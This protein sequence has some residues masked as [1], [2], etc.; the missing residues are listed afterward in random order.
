MTYWTCFFFIFLS[1][2][3]HDWLALSD[4]APD[5][6][7]AASVPIAFE[8]SGKRNEIKARVFVHTYAY[9]GSCMG[10]GRRKM[11]AGKNMYLK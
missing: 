2:S 8:T 7:Y 6:Q 1:R 4:M 10:D 9:I 11:H 3:K 5:A